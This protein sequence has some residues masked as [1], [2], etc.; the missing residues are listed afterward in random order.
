MATSVKTARRG[1]IVAALAAAWLALGGTAIAGEGTSASYN[2]VDYAALPIPIILGGRLVNYVFV[3][4]RLTASPGVDPTLLKERE[5]Y[6]RDRLLR[7]AH[8]QPFTRPDDLTRVDARRITGLVSAE[9][10]RLLGPRLLGRVEVA[11]ETPQRRTGLPTSPT[12]R[13]IIP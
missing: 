8:S 2:R 3:V 1:V 12:S 6:V 5:P 11:S 9:A 10:D 4:L 7:V 13:S